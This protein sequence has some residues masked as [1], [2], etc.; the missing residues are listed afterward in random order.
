MGEGG[1]ESGVGVRGFGL[2]DLGF[3]WCGGG[4]GV[5]GVVSHSGKREGVGTGFI[6]SGK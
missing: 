6:M 5:A 3:R 2:V 1:G 4:G